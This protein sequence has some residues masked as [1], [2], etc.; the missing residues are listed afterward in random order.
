MLD[1]QSWASIEPILLSFLE[2]PL[3]PPICL[4][5]L[6]LGPGSMLKISFCEVSSVM[7]AC[8]SR[9]RINDWEAVGPGKETFF[10][11]ELCK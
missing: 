3:P 5:S 2:E 10:E 8:H 7:I 9:G 6:S 4:G 1:S 11:E